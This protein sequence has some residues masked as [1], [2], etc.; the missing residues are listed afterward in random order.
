M[1]LDAWLTVVAEAAR[2]LRQVAYIAV[3]D[4]LL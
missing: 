3:Q 4:R 2:C 1:I